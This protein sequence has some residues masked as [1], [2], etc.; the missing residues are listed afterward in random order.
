MT[1]P[2]NIEYQVPATGPADPILQ[3]LLPEFLDAWIKDLGVTWTEI[4]ERADITEFQRFGH[5]IKGSFVQ[6]SFRDLSSVGREIMD[7]SDRGDWITA[8]ARVRAL[9]S[10]VNTMRAQLSSPSSSTT[11]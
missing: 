2:L 8:D 11:E 1:D 5:T 4:K 10:V 7:D 9:L 3:E 6:F